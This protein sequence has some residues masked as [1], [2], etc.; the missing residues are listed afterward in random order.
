M[1]EKTVKEKSYRFALRLIKAY[2]FLREERRGFVLSKQWLRSG[3][4]IGALVRETE[5]AQ[6][7]ADFVNKMNIAFKEANE[8]EYCLLLLKDSNYIDL[9]SFQLVHSGCAKVV[10]LLISI[11]KTTKENYASKK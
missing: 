1:K 2:K 10:K 7:K 8:T 9:K 5:Q 4:A 3:S 6:S 11:V